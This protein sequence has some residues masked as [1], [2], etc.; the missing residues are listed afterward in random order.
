MGA[1]QSTGCFPS[2]PIYEF[3]FTRTRTTEPLHVANTLP[4]MSLKA[5]SI[6]SRGYTCNKGNAKNNYPNLS[7][8]ETLFNLLVSLDFGSWVKNPNIQF[9]LKSDPMRR[10]IVTVC[11][12]YPQ[13][14]ECTILVSDSSEG[15]MSCIQFTVNVETGK[16][17]NIKEL[18]MTLDSIYHFSEYIRN[19]LRAYG[20]NDPSLA[21]TSSGQGLASQSPDNY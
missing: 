20:T 12:Q 18:D 17:G 2:N 14:R 11:T 6:T 15:P 3:F 21:R 19:E 10:H 7:E 9:S 13:G 8:V 4:M 16:F 5:M 1:E